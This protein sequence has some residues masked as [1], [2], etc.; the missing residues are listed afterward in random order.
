MDTIE[1]EFQTVEQRDEWYQICF[2]YVEQQKKFVK[3]MQQRKRGNLLSQI[4]QKSLRNL[5]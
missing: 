5:K 4:K 1:V 2:D 3:E